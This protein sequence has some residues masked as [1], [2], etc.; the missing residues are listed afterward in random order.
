MRARVYGVRTGFA[1][2]RMRLAMREVH[3]VQTQLQ[4]HRRLRWRVKGAVDP[5]PEVAIA[6][7]IPAQAGPPGWR[8]PTGS[9]IGTG[10]SA[11]SDGDEC[12]PNLDAH[13][14]GRR[15]HEGFDLELL[16][17]QLEEQFDR[18]ALFVNG[19]D[20]RGG[21]VEIIRQDHQFLLLVVQPDDNA[22]QVGQVR[23]PGFERFQ[24]NG[25]SRR[26]LPPLGT[27]GIH[28]RNWRWF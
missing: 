26:T 23:T 14:I 13:R 17:E 6:E 8:P 4:L 24:T 25:L 15:S 10:D 27:D 3:A 20:R 18:L 19:C 9:W 22:S 2:L 21:Q 16:L 28:A 5:L 11:R 7:Q 1:I 12:C